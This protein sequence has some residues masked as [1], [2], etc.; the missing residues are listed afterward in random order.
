MNP[1]SEVPVRDCSAVNIAM[2]ENPESEIIVAAEVPSHLRD[3]I[4][5]A[6]RWATPNPHQCDELIEQAS[7]EDLRPFVQT[8]EQRREAIDA[9]LDSLPKQVEQW[10]RAAVSFL[11]LVRNWNEAACELDV[12]ERHGA[13]GAHGP[14]EPGL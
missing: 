1:D 9:W 3:L 4:S 2:P 5:L 11:Y 8:V 6:H 12:R 13:T 14:S 10:P 7:T